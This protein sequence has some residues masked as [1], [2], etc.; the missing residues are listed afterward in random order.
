MK[1]KV[2]SF[3]LLTLLLPICANAQSLRDQQWVLGRDLN[4]L[5]PKG[6]A[7]VVDFSNGTPVFTHVSTAVQFSMEGSN[8]SICDNSGNLLFYTNGCKIMNRKHE[9]MLNGD[10]IIDGVIQSSFCWQ[11]GAPLRQAVLA[12]PS[13]GEKCLYYVFN[14]DFVDTYPPDSITVTLA[15]QHLYYHVVD[16]SRDTG[17]GEVISKY[18]IAVKDTFARGNIQATRHANGADWW[19]IVPKSHSNCY[20][21]SLLTSGGIQPAQ[22][23]CAGNIWEDRDGGAQAVFT[24]NGKK[25]IR[26]SNWDGLNIFDFDSSTGA[27]SNPTVIYFPNDNINYMAGVAVSPNSRYL[28]ACARSKVYQFDLKSSDIESSK[29]L[30]AEYDGYI[31]PNPTRFN[32]AALGPDGKIYISTFSD[33]YN[34]HVIHNP[35]LPGLAC[36][37]EQHGIVLPIHNY[38]SIPNLPYYKNQVTPG[39]CDSIYVS[40]HEPELS[41]SGEMSIYPNP[42][43]SSFVVSVP[44]QSYELSVVDSYGKVYMSYNLQNINE[45]I[46]VSTNTLQDGCYFLLLRLENGETL[47]KKLVILR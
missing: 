37:L 2:I 23:S 9:E 16:M 29:V 3:M 19:I 35:D 38:N 43:N 47:S 12:L 28:Y 8:S 46:E 4:N 17:Y 41:D 26:F 18:Q 44:F 30:I 32:L 10:S 21:L 11:G 39:E 45:S 27:L 31:N 40:S 36:N 6:D 22:L 20:F 14:L 1:N 42:A 34:L 5:D 7:I 24:P 15:P 25:Y 13:V 33:T